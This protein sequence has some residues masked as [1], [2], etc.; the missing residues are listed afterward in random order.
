MGMSPS[1]ATVNPPTASASQRFPRLA[2]LLNYLDSLSGRADLDVLSGMLS[3]L[4][5]TR[6]DIDSA[7][8]FGTRG[9]KRNTISRTD[10]YEL[11]ALCWRSG[12]ST[13]IHDHRGS[14][15]AFRIVQ[16]VGTEI[17]FERTPSGLVCPVKTISM[18]PGYICAAEDADIHQ[19]S[20]MQAAGQDLVTLHIYSPPLKMM[21]QYKF[22]PTGVDFEEEAWSP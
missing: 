8:V 7:C 2:P 6:A 9:Y 13:P 19:V 4:D 14:S 20:N 15:C 22:S 10:W 3:K 5:I 17:R 18:N 16:G 1:P 21:A 11:V 12:H